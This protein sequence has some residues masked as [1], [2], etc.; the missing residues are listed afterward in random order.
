MEGTVVQLLQ[1]Y[2]DLLSNSCPYGPLRPMIQPYLS[3]KPEVTQYLV[4]SQRPEGLLSLKQEE[5]LSETG[6]PIQGRSGL[7][8]VARNRSPKED[9]SIRVL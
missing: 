3:F 9:E 6:A 5:K 7:D 4:L 2:S 8:A 1:N